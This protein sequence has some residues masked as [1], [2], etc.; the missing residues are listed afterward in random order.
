[1]IGRGCARSRQHSPPSRCTP[2]I[3]PL[4]GPDLQE[5]IVEKRWDVLRDVLAEFDPSDIAQILIQVPEKEDVAIFRLL[6][7][8]LAGHVFAYLPPDQQ[9]T[10]LRSLTN[11]QMRSVLQEMTPDD[12]TKLFEEMPAEVTRRLLDTLSPDELRSARDLMGYPPQSAGRYMTP[13]Y[14]AL[15]PEMTSREALEHVRRTGRGKETLNILYL[16][17]DTGRLCEEL[18]LGSLVLADPDMK[19]SEIEDRPLVCIPA[20]AD[21]EDVLRAFEKYDRVA[22]PVTDAAGNM[23]GIITV[24]DVLDVAEREATEDIQKIGGSEALDAP[25]PTVTFWNMIRKRGGWLSALFLGEMLT[26]TAMGYFEAEIARAVVLALFVPLI[27][28]SGGNSGSQ[29]ATLIV[30]SLA[31]AELKLTDWWRV[32]LRELATGASLGMWL[33]G[34]GFLR[35]WLWQHLGWIDY[36]PHYL[37]VGLTVWSSLIGVVTFGSLTGSMLPFLLRR[38]GFDPATSSAPFVATLVDVTGLLIYFS[39]A[40]VILTGTLL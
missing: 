25:Y 11:D 5:L 7:R 9:E 33:G 10:L 4:L 6:P 13:R 30:R 19:V 3:G 27:I 38:L 24:D 26:A 35:V 31:L 40:V 29:A 23:L 28:S 32:F 20:K 22:L 21:R 2:M 16:V 8:D 39:M 15:R 36:G 12:Q 14:V 34:I 1:M 37:L 17:S 18:R